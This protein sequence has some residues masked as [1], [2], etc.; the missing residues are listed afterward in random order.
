[1][2]GQIF[3]LMFYPFMAV[4]ILFF[5][6]FSSDGLISQIR[7]SKT[8]LEKSSSAIES[9]NLALLNCSPDHFLDVC[10]YSPSNGTYFVRRLAT[11]GEFVKELIFAARE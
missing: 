9:S 2:K 5:F 11:D 1:M 4:T 7:A 10:D 3:E 6:R 8:I